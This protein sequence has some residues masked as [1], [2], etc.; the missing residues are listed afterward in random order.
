MLDKKK[1]YEALEAGEGNEKTIEALKDYFKTVDSTEAELRTTKSRFEAV[2][3]R[4]VA[5]MVQSFDLLQEKGIKDSDALV[6]IIGKGELSDSEIAKLKEE[7]S[8]KLETLN[9]DFATRE[10]E[11]L[12]TQMRDRVTLDMIEACHGDTKVA[13]SIARLAAIDGKVF[14]SENGEIMLKNGDESLK[15]SDSTSKLAESYEHLISK[16]PQINIGV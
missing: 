3:D 8:K 13:E 12:N 14:R 15:F 16:Y 2:G 10:N 4:D 9:S 7:Q 1:L 11:H 5:L 6:D